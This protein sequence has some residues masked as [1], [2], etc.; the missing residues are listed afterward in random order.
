MA[1][2]DRHPI[3]REGEPVEERF[4]ECSRGDTT[5]GVDPDVHVLGVWEPEIAADEQ[6]M[7]PTPTPNARGD[8]RPWPEP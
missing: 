4:C 8:R 5:Q 2:L 6:R 3:D 7:G 1:A